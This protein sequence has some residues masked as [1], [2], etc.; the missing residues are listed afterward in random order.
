MQVLV[1]LINAARASMV[2]V[3]SP[4]S[5]GKADVSTGCLSASLISHPGTDA[6]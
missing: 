4:P 6:E 5:S 3:S 2:R 1:S